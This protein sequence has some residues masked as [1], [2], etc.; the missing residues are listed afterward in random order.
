LSHAIFCYAPE[1][2]SPPIKRGTIPQ[3]IWK[4]RSRLER[5]DR[6]RP[7]S[8]TMGLDWFAFADAIYETFE[9]LESLGVDWEGEED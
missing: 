4:L 2:T 9:H 8:K 3:K 7:Q 6:H 1:L 5:L